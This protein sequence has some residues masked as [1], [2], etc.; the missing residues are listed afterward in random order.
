MEQT[1]K[2]HKENSKQTKLPLGVQF[3]H[4]IPGLQSKDCLRIILE[5][6]FSAD[7]RLKLR[8]LAKSLCKSSI[9]LIDHPNFKQLH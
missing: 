1:K 2:R 3:K 5:F 7:Q 4:F 9:Q 6:T 8:S